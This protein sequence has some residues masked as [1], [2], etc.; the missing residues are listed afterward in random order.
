M[1]RAWCLRGHV[2]TGVMVQDETNMPM[3]TIS[4]GKNISSIGNASL[5]EAS[6]EVLP[7]VL[8]GQ[9]MLPHQEAQSAAKVTFLFTSVL[10]MR[11]RVRVRL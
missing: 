6:T 7:R 2:C 10:P 11:V 4:V 3:T 5:S 1:F 8:K 9:I